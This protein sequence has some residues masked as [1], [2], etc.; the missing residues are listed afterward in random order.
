MSLLS[1]CQHTPYK[2]SLNILMTLMSITM[3]VACSVEDTPVSSNTTEPDCTEDT[4]PDPR[5]ICE[6]AGLELVTEEDCTNDECQ[7]VVIELV[8]GDNAEALCREVE[9][10][11]LIEYPDSSLICETEGLVM[12]TEEECVDADCQTLSF[13]LSCETVEVLC[14]QAEDCTEVGFPNP[15]SIC[16][17]EGLELASEEDCVDA[18]CQTI[19]FEI[20]CDM[21]AEVLCRQAEDCTEVGFPNPSSICEAEGLELASE[22]DCVDAEC[23]TITFAIACDMTAEVLC[24]EVDDNCLAYPTCA[25]GLVESDQ[26]CIRGEESCEDVSM[27]NVTI[28]CR[29][30]IICDAV[31]TCDENREYASAFACA[32]DEVDCYGSTVCGETIFC[33]PV[34]LCEAAPICDLG[35]EESQNPCLARESDTEC[36]TRT[37]C[38]STVACRSME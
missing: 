29:S 12:A 11:S 34:E 13:D 1:H 14:R 24:R 10:C 30:D 32:E 22:E 7:T 26:A 28:S 37:V 8:C 35:E 2:K 15:S 21:T 38:A 25:E 33:R 20:A 6:E 36:Y 19:T 17:A 18:E 23:Q 5:S 3:M 9:D 4:A 27:C 31:P 16:E